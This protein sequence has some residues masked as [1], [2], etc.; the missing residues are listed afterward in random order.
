LD[1][2]EGVVLAGVTVRSDQVQLLA[3][4]L[5]GD[6]GRKLELGL[7]SRNNL[8]GLNTTERREIVAALDP[9]PF[10]LTELREALVKQLRQAKERDARDQ[11][12][13]EATRMRESWRPRKP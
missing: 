6:L 1:G 5:K 3:K 8:V 9:A 11:R 10:G 13:R 2:R 4:L 7:S 12:Q